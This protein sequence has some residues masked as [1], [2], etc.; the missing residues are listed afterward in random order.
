MISI[1]ILIILIIG[2]YYVSRQ[3]IN[4][5]FH[6]LRKIFR[7]DHVVFSIVSLFFLPGTIIHE[8]SHMLMATLLNLHVHEVK[9]FPEWEK[10]YLKLG[11]VLYE[12]KDVVRGI[13]V[14]IAP[15]FIGLLFLWWMSVFNIFPSSNFWMNIFLGY[16]IFSV[17]SNMFS[18]KQDLI[19]IIYV[20]PLVI[21]IALVFYIFD[22]RL[23]FNNQGLVNAMVV[24]IDK[25]NIN[26]MI[27]LAINIGLIVI[28]KS[29]RIITK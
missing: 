1:S 22:I 25:I 10:N 24:V 14:G 7:N 17:S 26:L 20:L 6:A 4:E 12:K 16:V 21:I 18:S 11:K 28:L 5:L 15:V 9:I 23:T 29:F 27:S 19:D 13:I 2:L 8:L 3:T